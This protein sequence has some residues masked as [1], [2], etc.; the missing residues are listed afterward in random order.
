MRTNLNSVLSI[1]LE[2]FDTPSVSEVSDTLSAGLESLVVNETTLARATAEAIHE[3]TAIGDR[4]QALTDLTRLAT[5][6]E[7]L[8]IEVV[9]QTGRDPDSESLDALRISAMSVRRELLTEDQRRVVNDVAEGRLDAGVEGLGEVIRSVNAKVLFA[10][11][12]LFDAFKRSIGSSKKMTVDTI[13]VIDDLCKRIEKLP[14]VQFSASL[15]KNA[16]CIISLGGKANL[17]AACAAAP[18]AMDAWYDSPLL[19]IVAEAEKINNLFSQMVNAETLEAFELAKTAIQETK[20]LPIPET[21]VKVDYFRGKYYI[22]DLFISHVSFGNNCRFY[23]V[24]RPQIDS[25]ANTPYLAECDAYGQVFS[26]TGYD[27][28]IPVAATQVTYT[29][30]EILTAL[31]NLNIA[32]RAID[33]Y[34]EHIDLLG[35]VYTNY[36]TACKEY[37]SFLKREYVNNVIIRDLRVA[38][39]MVGSLFDLGCCPTAGVISCMADIANVVKS[40]VYSSNLGVKA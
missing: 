4:Q 11:G 18:T 29:K 22:F 3:Q 6:L 24:A 36:A 8:M 37:N 28:R 34:Y 14:D 27:R 15:D 39:Y 20:K 33:Q 31:A 23:Y 38:S 2:G 19:A 16:S 32:L 9:N 40:I 30:A 25:V 26:T 21:A 7:G 1:G 12:N 17:V 35:T 10:I 5:G 13:R